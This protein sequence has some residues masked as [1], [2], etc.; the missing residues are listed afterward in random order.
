MEDFQVQV[1]DQEWFRHS[2]WFRA[3]QI[4]A[5]MRRREII[6]NVALTAAAVLMIVAAFAMFGGY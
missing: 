3:E 5:Q 6:I 2:R 4:E 1:P